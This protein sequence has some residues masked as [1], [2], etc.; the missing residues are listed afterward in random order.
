MNVIEILETPVKNAVPA[1]RL[2]IIGVVLAAVA[3]ILS[4]LGFNLQKKCHNLLKHLEAVDH[5][6]Q[7]RLPSS[8]VSSPDRTRLFDLPPSPD[9]D[10]ND[11]L[12]T[13]NSTISAP[14]YRHPLWLWGIALVALGSITDFFALGFAAQSIVAPLGSLTLVANTVFAPLLLNEQ[15]NSYDI[16]ATAAIVC[17][18]V[19]SVASASHRDTFYAY[20]EA[21]LL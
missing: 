14:Y 10:H 4:N 21:D 9:R 2:W 20:V 6:D 13:N 7:N 17:G 11:E 16:I 19:I 8:A 18:S 5:V 1:D 3:S 12:N 15:I